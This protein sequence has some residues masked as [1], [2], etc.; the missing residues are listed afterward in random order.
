MFENEVID[1]YMHYSAYYAESK[2]NTGFRI[3]FSRSKHN[4]LYRVDL[5]EGKLGG[6]FVVKVYKSSYKLKTNLI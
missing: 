5:F 3:L 4:L 6:F 1:R 2:K